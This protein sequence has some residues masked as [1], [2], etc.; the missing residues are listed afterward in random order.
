VTPSVS[1]ECEQRATAIGDKFSAAYVNLEAECYPAD[2]A[3]WCGYE[4]SPECLD[5]YQ[6]L[7]KESNDTYNAYFEECYGPGW[8]GQFGYS[9]SS[10]SDSV[11]TTRSEAKASTAQVTAAPTKKEMLKRIKS[12]KKQLRRAK[13]NNKKIRARC[14]K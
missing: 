5:R 9:D 6:A 3:G 4:L 8:G 13:A 12:L 7:N 14:A 11:E 1:K 2:G 10:G